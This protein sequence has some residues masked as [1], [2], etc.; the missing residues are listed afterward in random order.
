MIEHRRTG[1]GDAAMH[2][3][4]CGGKAFGAHI[5][6]HGVDVLDRPQSGAGSQAIAVAEFLGDQ[7]TGHILGEIGREDAAIGRGQHRQLRA[8]LND[9]RDRLFVDR[10][11]NDGRAAISP[12]SERRHGLQSIA[13]IVERSLRDFCD[14]E[15]A[16]C[17]KTDLGGKRSKAVASGRRV[18]PHQP[19]ADETRQ[20][21]MRAAGR[22]A[23]NSGEIGQFHR[24]I[25]VR[26]HAQQRGADFDRL[27]AGNVFA[28]T[29]HRFSENES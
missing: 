11:A 13:Q 17:S 20:I 2:G 6:D 7:R 9:Q 4:L 24:A 28:A 5:G 14:I 12:N 8:K 18:L 26:Q 22:H 27:H 16:Q 29:R 19:A 23:G 10:T 15:I 21:F 25:A 1:G 3:A